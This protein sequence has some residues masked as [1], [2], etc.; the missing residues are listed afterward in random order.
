MQLPDKGGMDALMSRIPKAV[1]CLFATIMLG[2]CGTYVPA[3]QEIPG[4][5]GDAQILVNA[6]V[7]SIHCELKNAV[8]ACRQK[9]RRERP[10]KT[11]QKESS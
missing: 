4:G 8:K 1:F 10:T 3:I 2:G 6:I 5:S 7:R 9:R 11:G